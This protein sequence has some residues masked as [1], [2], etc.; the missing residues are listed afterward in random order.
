MRLK[1]GLLYVNTKQLHRKSHDELYY[2][3]LQVNENITYLFW[4]IYLGIHRIRVYSHLALHFTLYALNHLL[5]FQS[6]LSLIAI[7]ML[8]MGMIFI[9]RVKKRD[10][11]RKRELKDIKA[12]FF[13]VLRITYQTYIFHQIHVCILLL[14][15]ENKHSRTFD[16]QICYMKFFLE[17]FESLHNCTQFETNSY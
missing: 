10:K 14:F 3:V 6:F 7:S 2:Y 11:V 8:R 17:V 13:I 1:C 15:K 9:M 12:H 5:I 4:C 16:F